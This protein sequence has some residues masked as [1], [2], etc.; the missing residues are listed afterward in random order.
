MERLEVINVRASLQVGFGAGL[1]PTKGVEV[2]LEEIEAAHGL[3]PATIPFLKLLSTLIHT[4]RRVSLTDRIIDSG[5]LGTIPETLGQPYRL[6][7]ISPFVGFVSI[8]SSQRFR[9]GNICVPQIDG[10]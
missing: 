3:Y 5:T 10:R 9:C 4:S 8:M 1:L 6:P 7:G 2:E